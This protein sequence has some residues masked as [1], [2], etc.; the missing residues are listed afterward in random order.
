M[1]F[2]ESSNRG[3]CWKRV[4]QVFGGS[5]AHTGV[6]EQR[7]AQQLLPER[8]AH[9]LILEYLERGRLGHARWAWEDQLE[10]GPIRVVLQ[11]LQRRRVWVGGPIPCL[12]LHHNPVLVGPVRRLAPLTWPED[13]LRLGSAKPRHLWLLQRLRP[14]PYLASGVFLEPLGLIHYLFNSLI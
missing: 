6:Q 13:G 7:G 1:E 10:A 14:L 8:E 11:G 3:E 9:V 2:F 4:K 5:G 12:R